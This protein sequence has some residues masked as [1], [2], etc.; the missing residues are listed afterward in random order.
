MFD[1]NDPAGLMAMIREGAAPDRR[2]PGGVSRAVQDAAGREVR[3]Y[4]GERHQRASAATTSS[5][6]P[7]RLPRRHPAPARPRHHR[8]TLNW[9]DQLGTPDDFGAALR[10]IMQ[11]VKA[12][13]DADS[14][15]LTPNPMSDLLPDNGLDARRRSCGMSPR[16]KGSR[17][18]MP[19]TVGGLHDR[20]NRAARVPG[21]PHQPST[22]VGHRVY[23]L[24]LMQ[25]FE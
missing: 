14:I 7:P 10:H 2:P 19:T 23:A 6:A 17:W 25:L 1:P 21:E 13:T 3:P 12:N 4:R 9:S 15:L 22:A 8:R 11:A 16:P 5:D 24:A 18:W 20:P